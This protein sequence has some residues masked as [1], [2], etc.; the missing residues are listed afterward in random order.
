VGLKERLSHGRFGERRFG[1]SRLLIFGARKTYA[2]FESSTGQE[3]RNH[4]LDIVSKQFGCKG[5]VIE[6]CK[7]VVWG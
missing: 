5:L 2:T 4:S 7:A 1:V 3:K 6:D